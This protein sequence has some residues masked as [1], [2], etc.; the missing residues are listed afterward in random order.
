MQ[1]NLCTAGPPPQPSHPGGEASRSLHLSLP[2]LLGATGGHGTVTVA[3]A[4]SKTVTG[5]LCQTQRHKSSVDHTL[6]LD[7]L[8]NAF[9]KTF[10]SLQTTEFEKRNIDYTAHR[11][12]GGFSLISDS[13]IMQPVLQGICPRNTLPTC[14]TDGLPWRYRIENSMERRDKRR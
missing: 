9:I 14:W 6:S 2:I 4:N 13:V 1:V 5:L 10:Y 11:E 12:I 3:R 7:P 8:K